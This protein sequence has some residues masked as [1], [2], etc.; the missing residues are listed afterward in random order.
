MT[1][2]LFL[3]KAG[4][5]FVQWFPTKTNKKLVGKY[6]RKI[7]V[8][9]EIVTWTQGDFLM[10]VS[11]HDY[12]SFRIFF[13]GEYDPVM[14]NMLKSHIPEGGVCWDVG[15]ERGWFS[16]LMGRLVGPTGRV[17]G[18][19]AFPSN[20]EKLKKNIELNKFTWVYMHNLAIS[21]KTCRM[22]FV[23]P[24]DEITNH[25]DYLQSCSGVGYLAHEFR[26]GCIEV[27]TMTLDEHAE[28]VGLNRL[29]FI[30]MD[31]EGAE[32]AGLRGAKK[33]ILRYR[34]KLAVEYN[35]ATAIRAGTSMEELDEL[36]ESYGYDRFT[37][38]GRLEKLH[39]EKWKD[40]SDEEAV[41]N[42]YCFPR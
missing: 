24:S 16:L 22:W 37:F 12:A 33:T 35:R 20:Y 27:P 30:K 13:W 21:D 29:D 31:I 19:E 23:P 40:C 38:F 5:C 14:T 34:P 8:R 1:P 26:Q 3:T 10:R 42:V 36:L 17:D 32:T 6:F 18:F 4:R 39:L 11:P 7:C 41:F 28:K 2:R 15:T 25:V 9:D